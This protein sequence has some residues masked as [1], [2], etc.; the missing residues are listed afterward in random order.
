MKIDPAK[1]VK[2][3][4]MNFMGKQEALPF[5]AGAVAWERRHWSNS[6]EIDF[7]VRL[8]WDASQSWIFVTDESSFDL[9]LFFLGSG[10]CDWWQ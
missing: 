9:S 6:A 7:L 2:Q 8:N 10:H 4:E 5:R 3:I 1:G